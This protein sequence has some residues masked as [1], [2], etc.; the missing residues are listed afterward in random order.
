MMPTGDGVAVRAEQVSRHDQMGSA[1]IPALGGATL[2]VRARAFLV[3][4]GSSRSGKSRRLSSTAGPDR[5]TFGAIFGKG[6][7]CPT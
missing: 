7:V 6:A 1:G 4:L 2:E 5:P 3:L